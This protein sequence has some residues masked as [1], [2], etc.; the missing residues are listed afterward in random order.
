MYIRRQQ[1]KT[2]LSLIDGESLPPQAVWI[3]TSLPQ[4]DRSVFAT[5]AV[6]FTVGGVTDGPNGAVVTFLDL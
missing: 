4:L 1:K 6:E 2:T 5:G 3:P